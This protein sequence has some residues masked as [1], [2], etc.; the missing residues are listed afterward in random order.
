MTEHYKRYQDLIRKAAWEKAKRNSYGL[1]FEELMGW[2]NLA[3]AEALQTHDPEKGAFSTHLTYELKRHLGKAMKGA[4]KHVENVPLED[5]VETRHPRPGVRH[6]DLSALLNTGW[7]DTEKAVA[8]TE[9]LS[10]LSEEAQ[11]LVGMVFNSPLE[12]CDLTRER[13]SVSLPNIKKYLASEGWPVRANRVV[14]EIKAMLRS[15]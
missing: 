4:R 13:I 5:W 8:F 3:Y 1:C 2:G 15:L 7:L 14:K 6:E 10:N 9:G 11:E 12:F